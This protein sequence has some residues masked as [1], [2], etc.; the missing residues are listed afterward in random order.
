MPVIRNSVLIRSSP[1]E[2]FDYLSDLRAE[3]EWNPDCHVMEKLT[4]GPI[5]VGT[6]YRAKWKGSPYVEVETISFERPHSWKMHANG[7]LEV[8]FSVRLTPAAEGTTLAVDFEPIPHGWFKLVFPLFL[9]LIRRQERANMIR[10]RDALER[11]VAAPEAKESR[12]S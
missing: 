2:A 10:I 8:N 4:D 1:E 12:S 6:R 7:S 3:L 9:I 11:R 5:G